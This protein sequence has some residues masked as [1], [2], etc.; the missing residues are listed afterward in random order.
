MA[1]RYVHA[2]S[3]T[4]FLK[5]LLGAVGIQY[6]SADDKLKF[7]DDNGTNVRAVVTEDQ[8]QTLSNK[9][10]TAPAGTGLMV[11]KSGV[12]T[13]NGA[14]TSY[15]LTIPVPAGAVVHSIQVI[16]QALWNGTSAALDVGD[17]AD[18]NGYFAAVNLKATDLLVGEVLDHAHSAL[19]GGKEGAYLVAAT[20]QRGPAATNF[21]R[22][23]AAGS[24]IT[25]VVTPG[26]ADG[27]QGRTLCLV[28]Y[29]IGETIAQVAA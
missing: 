9:T 25:F 16:A 1:A 18:P 24:N 29:S 6:D 7:I 28:S 4:G 8:V 22:Y 19:W 13:E 11:T 3:G 17:T 21:G 14:G 12:L 15:T 2:F 20:G 10:F 27:S 5:A 23:Y 26:A